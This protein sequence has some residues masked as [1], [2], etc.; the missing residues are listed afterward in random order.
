MC[1]FLCKRYGW[2]LDYVLKRITLKQANFLTKAAE[3]NESIGDD[4]NEEED[5]FGRTG[6]SGYK[7]SNRKASVITEDDRRKHRALLRKKGIRVSDTLAKYTKNKNVKIKPSLFSGKSKGGNK[8][9]DTI[10]DFLSKAC[11]AKDFKISKK[12]RDHL[13]GG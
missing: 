12:V 5:Q 7:P 4:E 10:G 11:G 9:V 6:K 1:D 13:S 2:N 8:S 3:E